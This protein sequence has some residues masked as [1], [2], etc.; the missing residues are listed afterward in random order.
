MEAHDLEWQRFFREHILDRGYDFFR[1]G[2][3]NDLKKVG[4]VLTATVE[5]TF[6][7]FVKI[8][9]NGELITNMSCSCPYAENGNYCKHM[10]AVLFKY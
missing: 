1:D 6:D 7:Y 8:S 3:V 9:F 5:G 10:A 2:A 4:D